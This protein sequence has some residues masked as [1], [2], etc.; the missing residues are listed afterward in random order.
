VPNTK[1][2]KPPAKRIAGLPPFLHHLLAEL[3][4]EQGEKSAG[5]LASAAINN[6]PLDSPF[7]SLADWCEAMVLERDKLDGRIDAGESLSKAE[8]AYAEARA[9]G[10][11]TIALSLNTGDKGADRLLTSLAD[12][13]GRDEGAALFILVITRIIAFPSW[14]GFLANQTAGSPKQSNKTKRKQTIVK[15]LEK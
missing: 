3:A 6:L 7:I 15:I 8:K 9:A 14:R 13:I 11:K 2:D 1:R 10:S 12:L 4:A 5:T